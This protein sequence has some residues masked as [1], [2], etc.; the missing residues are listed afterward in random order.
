MGK[1]IATRIG[2]RPGAGALIGQ[3]LA[4]VL[5]SVRQV[6]TAIKHRRQL[7]D[8]VDCEDHRLS[9]MGI[10][11]D[12]LHAALSEPLWRAI[13]RQL[14]RAAPASRAKPRR[15]P[16]QWRPRNRDADPS[17]GTERLPWV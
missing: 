12:D 17:H 11:R 13:R 6:V 2:K 9:D 10:T 7:A 15:C 5:L 16:G 3:A 4:V 1:S 8:L 14:L